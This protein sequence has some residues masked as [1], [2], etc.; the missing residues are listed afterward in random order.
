MN[1]ESFVE[2][3]RKEYDEEMH[4]VD[5]ISGLPM[6]YHFYGDNTD[7]AMFG[8]LLAKSFNF[9]VYYTYTG[10]TGADKVFLDCDKNLLVM[11]E[12]KEDNP[13]YHKLYKEWMYDNEW[14]P[15]I[16][17]IISNKSPVQLFNLNGEKLAD[18]LNR[19]S[20]HDIKKEFSN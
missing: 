13:D 11:Y 20:L 5:H 3:L 1:P 19:V 6:V 7:K 14:K 16:L 17:C 2:R 4:D 10:N 12:I 18:Y 8:Y 15:E 9:S